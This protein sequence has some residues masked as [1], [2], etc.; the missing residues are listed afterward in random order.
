[1]SEEGICQSQNENRK[2]VTKNKKK[3]EEMEH[4]HWCNFGIHST[5]EGH[6]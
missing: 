5:L 4:D 1:M 2:Q 6:V 3:P